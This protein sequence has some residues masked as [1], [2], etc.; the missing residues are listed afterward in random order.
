MRL[1]TLLL[2]GALALATTSVAHAQDTRM[3]LIN[4]GDGTGDGAVVQARLI[5]EWE[6]ANPG[7]AIDVEYVP[8]GQCQEKST[9]LATRR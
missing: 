6:A 8:W 1:R 4:C 2:G 9:T 7:Y 3:H 5:S